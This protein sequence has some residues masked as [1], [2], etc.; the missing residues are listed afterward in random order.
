MLSGCRL[1]RRVGRWSRT[2]LGGAEGVGVEVGRCIGGAVKRIGKVERVEW[3]GV[4]ETSSAVYLY[5]KVE[6]DS[7]GL[8][9]VVRGSGV[10][11]RRM[12]RRTP[13][14][15]EVIDFGKEVAAETGIAERGVEVIVTEIGVLWVGDRHTDSG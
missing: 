8:K 3:V 9:L 11:H 4:G 5:R 14:R 2:A 13:V 10:I 12:G 15:K 1:V 6:W 7:R